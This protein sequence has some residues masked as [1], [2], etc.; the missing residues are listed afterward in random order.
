LMLT[1]FSHALKNID[2]MN[3]KKSLYPKP[4]SK[5]VSLKII[6]LLLKISLQRCFIWGKFGKIG[7]NFHRIE[8][9]TQRQ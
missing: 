1:S 9:K 5:N 7:Q 3:I 8:S 6:L 4:E 2:E